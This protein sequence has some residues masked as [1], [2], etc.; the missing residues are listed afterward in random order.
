MSTIWQSGVTTPNPSNNWTDNFIE[1]N[2]TSVKK[3]HI[4][5]LRS[6]LEGMNGHYHIVGGT[7]T[8]K[9]PS[10]PVSWSEP[11]EENKTKIRAIHITELRDSMEALDNHTH[12]AKPSTKKIYADEINLDTS[13]LSGPVI[14]DT[15]IIRKPHIDELRAACNILAGH[16]HR[17]CCECECTCTCTCTCTST[18]S[19]QCCNK[20]HCCD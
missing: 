19:E 10:I 16:V 20:C 4:D 15:T 7:K 1:A 14:E 17:V 18:C 12:A 8:F 5:E 13:W 6:F 2:S 9:D 3:R 11:I